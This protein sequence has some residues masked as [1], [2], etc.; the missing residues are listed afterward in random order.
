[1]YTHTHIRMFAKTK[2]HLFKAFNFF[3]CHVNS[4][5]Q[6]KNTYKQKRDISSLY[7]LHFR[8]TQATCRGLSGQT[9]GQLM[10]STG[11]MSRNTEQQITPRLCFNLLLPSLLRAAAS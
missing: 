11:V 6:G 8:S 1:M 5:F 7:D 4:V 9:Q 3:L 2:L 10:D